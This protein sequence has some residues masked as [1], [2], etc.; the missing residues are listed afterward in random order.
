[1]FNNA[2][3]KNAKYEP[4]EHKVEYSIKYT[5]QPDTVSNLNKRIFF[6]IKGCFRNIAEAMNR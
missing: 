6:E 1:M 5:Y 3:L 2:L 4:V